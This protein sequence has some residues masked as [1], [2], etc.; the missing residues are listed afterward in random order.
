MKTEIKLKP[1]SQSTEFYG[2]VIIQVILLINVLLG[3]LKLPALTLISPEMAISIAGGIEALWLMFRQINKNKELTI[4]QR[5]RDSESNEQ[6]GEA[7]N[8]ANNLQ[9]VQMAFQNQMDDM[10]KR[11]DDLKKELTKPGM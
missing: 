7:I 10:A 11:M 6:L 1:G 9:S 4:Q 8:A 3:M 2:K 5:V